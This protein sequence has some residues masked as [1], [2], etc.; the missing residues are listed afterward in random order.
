MDMEQLGMEMLGVALA[1]LGV[2]MYANRAG[3][4][5][6]VV[7]LSA[8][9]FVASLA[10][11]AAWVLAH[12]ARAA[13]VMPTPQMLASAQEAKKFEF[14]DED[15]SSYEYHFRDLG[16]HI[17]WCAYATGGN[18]G[19]CKKIAS[20]MVAET[21]RAVRDYCKTAAP[22]DNT[23][24]HAVYGELWDLG[25]KCARGRMSRLPVAMA[26]DSEGYVRTQWKLLQ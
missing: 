16:G 25:Y 5:Y 12:S 23:P 2:V 26:L 13:E 15:P 9:V 17:L 10:A 20:T 3:Y 19:F 4:L 7:R 21:D 6:F 18:G 11:I 8:V 24:P 14:P 22:N 1:A